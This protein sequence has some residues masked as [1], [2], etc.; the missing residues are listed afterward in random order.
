M[1]ETLRYV[2]SAGIDKERHEN[3]TEVLNMVSTNGVVIL[4]DLVKKK[5]HD[6]GCS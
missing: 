4:A 1:A 5:L 3:V 2:A 6:E